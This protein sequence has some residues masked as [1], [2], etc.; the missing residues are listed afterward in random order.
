MFKGCFMRIS[1]A[2]L[3][4]AALFFAIQPWVQAPSQSTADDA[5]LRDLGRQ[6]FTS[7]CGKCHDADAAKKLPDGSTLLARLAASQ[8][9]KARLATRTKKMS[10]Q[11]AR[12][13]DLYVE[14]LVARY[15]SAQ[16]S[17]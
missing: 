14:D 11:E 13:I 15:R 7:Q 3:L 5:A 4:A 1:R 9:I 12:G 2:T 16:S 17:H 6:V 8:D 10:A